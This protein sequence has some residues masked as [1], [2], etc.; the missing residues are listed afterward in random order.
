MARL[1][2]SL[3]FSTPAQCPK[4]DAKPAYKPPKGN[5]APSPKT[6]NGTKYVL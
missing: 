5:A 2:Q 3:G 1:A 6:V 4:S